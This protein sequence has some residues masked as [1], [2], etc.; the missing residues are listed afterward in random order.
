MGRRERDDAP[1]SDA[2]EADEEPR[3]RRSRSKPKKERVLHTRIPAVLEAELKAAA[4]GLRV[5][6]SNLVRTILEDAVTIADRATDHVEDR[7]TNAAR[8]VLDGRERV[9][10][11]RR[12]EP[13]ALDGVIAFQPIII[14]APGDCAKCGAELEPGDDAALGVTEREGPKVFVCAEC[15]PKKR[16]KS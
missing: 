13:D 11:A 5:P 9:R 16:S 1:D 2:P 14:A 8:S 7:I 4:E 10:K 15:L 12:D 3:E 6:V